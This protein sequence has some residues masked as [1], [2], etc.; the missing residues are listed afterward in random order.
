MMHR[1][2]TFQNLM[3]NT[4]VPLPDTKRELLEA[5]SEREKQAVL[6]NESESE[7]R[8]Q[9]ETTS[10]KAVQDYTGMFTRSTLIIPRL[11]RV[12]QVHHGSFT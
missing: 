10:T 5:S 2:Q 1:K 6:V 8:P 7:S 4:P 9:L 12:Q 11:R 3:P